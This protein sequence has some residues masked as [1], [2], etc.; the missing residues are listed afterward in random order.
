MS[1]QLVPLAVLATELNCGVRQLEE[2]H[3]A[4][5]I[6]DDAGIRCMPGDVVRDLIDRRD[7]KVEAR[8]AERLSREQ[9]PSTHP[10]RDR[11]KALSAAQAAMP[12]EGV[13]DLSLSE[14]AYARL[15]A[16]ELQD[17]YDAAA[18]Q[19]HEMLTGEMT[20]HRITERD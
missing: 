9:H 11:V 2:R 1:D 13:A 5:I 10:V 7:A 6:R 8:R 15:T 20:M 12:I 3:A 16:H 4:N 18:Q 17:K 14:S 19:R